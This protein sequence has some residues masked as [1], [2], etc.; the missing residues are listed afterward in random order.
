M[1]VISVTGSAALWLLALGAAIFVASFGTLVYAFRLARRL[2]RLV[3]Q[4]ERESLPVLRDA[5]TLADHAATEM[6]R[7]G[8]VIGTS[9]AVTATVDSA[10]R[11][12]YRLFANPFVKS[13]AFAAGFRS[14]TRRL[15]RGPGPGDRRRTGGPVDR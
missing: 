7:V 10:S 9:E 15:V 2:S 14:G 11:L 6:V 3:G 12:A 8:D 13:A 4:M 1:G 5:R